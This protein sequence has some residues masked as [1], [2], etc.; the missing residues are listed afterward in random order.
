V[1]LDSAV[2]IMGKVQLNKKLKAEEVNSIIAFLSSLTGD[3]KPSAKNIPP[4]LVNK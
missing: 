2:K 1:Q 4:E 3:I